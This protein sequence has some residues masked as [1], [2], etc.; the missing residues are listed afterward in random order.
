M[1]LDE[2]IEHAKEVANYQ[3]NECGKQHKQLAEWL[4]ELKSRRKF[5]DSIYDIEVYSSNCLIEA[6]KAKFKHWNSVKLYHRHIGGWVHH[7][8]WVDE[9]DNKMYEFYQLETL[10]HWWNYFRFAGFLKVRNAPEEL[11][12][13]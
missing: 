5:K 11:I 2:A 13:I 10:N 8:F 4:E 3:C 12:H 1:T 7:W 6:L 9:R